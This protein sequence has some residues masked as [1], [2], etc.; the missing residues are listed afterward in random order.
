MAFDV[1]DLS[2]DVYGIV[3]T[4]ISLG[5]LSG[6]AGMT[7]RSMERN[8]YDRP[9]SRRRP[10]YREEEYEMEERYRRPKTSSRRKSSKSKSRRSRQ[11]EYEDDEY[12]G[13]RSYRGYRSP[14]GM[15]W[16]DRSGPMNYW[17]RGPR[18]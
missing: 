6:M 3:G 15:S 10:Y 5:V 18:W 12:T 16:S 7:M 13:Y 2:S 17:T 9:M 11:R 8:L 1:G 14:Y 4:G